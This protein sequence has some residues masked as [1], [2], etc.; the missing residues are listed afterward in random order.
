MRWIIIII[1][2][3]LLTGCEFKNEKI[4][5]CIKEAKWEGKDYI[6]DFEDDRRYIFEENPPVSLNPGDNV[7]ITTDRYYSN[8]GNNEFVEVEK[9][10]AFQRPATGRM[11]ICPRCQYTIEN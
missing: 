3:L 7:I 10:D 4:Q 11:T 6:V 5:G 2:V 1:F 9:V 8:T